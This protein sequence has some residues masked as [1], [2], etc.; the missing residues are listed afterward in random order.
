V[1]TEPSTGAIGQIVNVQIKLAQVHDLYGLDVACI[2]NPAILIGAEHVDGTVFKGDNSFFVDKGFQSDGHWNLAASLLKPSPVFEG[3]GTAFNLH[4][5]VAGIGTT[6]ITC[7][8]MAVDANGFSVSITVENGE[9]SNESV[10]P[11]FT[12]EVTLVP[13]ATTLPTPNSTSVPTALSVSQPNMVQGVVHFQ[14]RSDSSGIMLTLLSGGPTGAILGQTQTNSDGAFQFDNLMPGVYALQFLGEGHI[15]LIKT[16][17]IAPE[18]VTRLQ[19]TLRTGDTNATL[20]CFGGGSSVARQRSRPHQHLAARGRDALR[21]VLADGFLHLVHLLLRLDEALRHRIAHQRVPM[22]LELDDFVVGQRQP[23]LLL[24]LEQIALFHDQLVL[25]FGFFVRHEGID[26]LADGLKFRLIK[27]GLA[28]FE[29]FLS[30]D[31]FVCR[32]LHNFLNLER[33]A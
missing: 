21:H 10:E 9:F 28:K 27:N 30:E 14:A 31:G 29:R 19:I 3:N 26:L 12:P 11:I 8:V 16:F 25:R 22:L 7:Q 1:Q 23:H 32:G 13:P 6:A 5:F 24:M 20:R 4:Y 17:S 18:D 2:V 15:Q 33:V